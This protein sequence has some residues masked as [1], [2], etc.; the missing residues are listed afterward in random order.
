VVIVLDIIEIGFKHLQSLT[1]IQNSLY[2]RVLDCRCLK[3]ISIISKTITTGVIKSRKSKVR[4]YNGQKAKC[5]TMV[6]RPN[7]PL[8]QRLVKQCEG[9]DMPFLSFL[10]SEAN[11]ITDSYNIVVDA[12]LAI[13]TSTFF[14]VSKTVA[15][16]ALGG[17]LKLKPNRASTTILYESVIKIY[18]YLC[19]YYHHSGVFFQ[20]NWG[21]SWS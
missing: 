6:K 11:L 15:K 2:F 5:K 8:F 14:S 12:L 20:I 1:V 21:P 9:M 3:P 10:P 16:S 19:I 17:P 4:Q 7:K 18:S 13:G